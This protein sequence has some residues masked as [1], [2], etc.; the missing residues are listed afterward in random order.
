[1]RIWSITDG[2]VRK[3]TI[4]MDPTHV[5]PVRVS[6]SKSGGGTA[7]QQR[8]VLVGA[9]EPAGSGSF[10]VPYTS[11]ATATPG[12][13]DWLGW[14]LAALGACLVFGLASNAGAAS[15]ESTLP[16]GA[17]PGQRRFR[18]ARLATGS[19]ALLAGTLA[20]GGWNRGTAV[21][22]DYRR[23]L[24][25]PQIVKTTMSVTGAR[26]LTLDVVDTAWQFDVAGAR[27]Q[28]NRQ[29]LTPL[30]PDHGKVMH[31]LPARTGASLMLCTRAV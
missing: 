7:A 22:Q 27:R 20:F 21:E 14:V 6:T 8:V 10:I 5:A 2:C 1:V 13:P 3:A 16:S 15:R 11:V 31:I 4:R 18:R 30:M 23:S 9:I 28:S 17:V 26:T 25:R 24:D 19:A 29:T 12:T